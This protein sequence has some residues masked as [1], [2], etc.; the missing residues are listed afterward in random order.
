MKDELSLREMV[1]LFQ[2]I[3][4]LRPRRIVFTGGE[5]LFRTDLFDLAYALHDADKEHN[6]Q[7]CINSNGTLINGE[8][9]KKLVNLFDDIR[10]S[11]DGLREVNDYLR[12]EGTFERALEAIDC[13]QMA[14]GDPTISV[15]ITS[16]NISGVKHFLSFLVG[17][18]RIHNV[19]LS[20][21]RASGRGLHRRDLLC[22]RERLIQ[23]T[24]EFWQEHFGIGV[25]QWHRSGNRDTGNKEFMN[26]GVGTYINIYPD[27]SVYPCHLLS[28]PEFCIGDVRSENLY[29]IYHRSD[30]MRKLRAL[31]FEEIAQC[32][33]CFQELST[34]GACLGKIYQENGLR[35]RLVGLFTEKQMLPR[36]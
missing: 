4:Y 7:R 13:I 12:G 23:A 35:D 8:I 29:A 2:D 10:I 25:G 17:E 5:P 14:G 11:I 9:A 22:S 28:F 6:I 24:A 27:G 21:F 30:L 26:C 32:A 3:V 18:K 34:N 20:L 19:H 1:T 33:E 36:G 16:I 31:N 15:T